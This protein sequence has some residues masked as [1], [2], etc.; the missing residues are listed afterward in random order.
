MLVALEFGDRRLGEC[1]LDG[2]EQ[3]EDGVEQGTP[4]FAAKAAAAVERLIVFPGVGHVGV[5][6]L[7]ERGDLVVAQAR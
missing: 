2:E 7:G 3:G 5:H 1:R 6:F 4:E